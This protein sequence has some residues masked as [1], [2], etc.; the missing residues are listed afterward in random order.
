MHNFVKESFFSLTFS[1]TFAGGQ[2]LEK[3]FP[4]GGGGGISADFIWGKNMKQEEKKDE[5]LREKSF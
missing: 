3:Y 5:N 1:E 4:P 2:Y